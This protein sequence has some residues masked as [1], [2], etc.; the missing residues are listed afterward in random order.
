MH[1][2]ILVAII[3]PSARTGKAL[4]E[5]M[6]AAVLALSTAA[7]KMIAMDSDWMYA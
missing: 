1:Q 5:A 3:V 4:S 7:M 2:P 6:V